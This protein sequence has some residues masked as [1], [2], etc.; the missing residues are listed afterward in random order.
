M[1]KKNAIGSSQVFF[2]SFEFCTQPD[3]QSLVD[4]FRLRVYYYTY[5]MQL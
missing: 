3:N 2:K 5:N 4:K 1:Q